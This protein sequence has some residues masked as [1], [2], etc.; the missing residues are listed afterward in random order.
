MMTAWFVAVCDDCKR[1]VGAGRYTESE[2]SPR[3]NRDA[4][5]RR[6]HD[7]DE[8]AR[9]ESFEAGYRADTSKPARRPNYAELVDD[10]ESADT[11]ATA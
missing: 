9:L 4:H 7:G 6:Y 5:N 8:V 1:I 10:A 2:E 3:I 11:E